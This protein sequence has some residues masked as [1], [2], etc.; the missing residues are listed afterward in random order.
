MS[1]FFAFVFHCVNYNSVYSV[2]Q[3][4]FVDLANFVKIAQIVFT[5][6]IYVEVTNKSMFK[7]NFIK[8]CNSKNV[9][10]TVVC[11]C[12]GLSNAA[13]SKWDDNS[14]P[15]KAT[16]FKI[17][18]YFGVT[19]ESLLSEDTETVNP[20]PKKELFDLIDQMD[21]EQL[22]QLESYVGYLVDKKNNK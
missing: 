13:F 18:E 16:L 3:S 19:V 9:P 1:Y 11:Q 22:K 7:N 6:I 21:E 15:R 17:A 5:K 4:Y 14:V 20:N 10:P 8:L 12:I 2:C